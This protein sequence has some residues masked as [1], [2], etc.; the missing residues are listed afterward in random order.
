MQLLNGDCMELL[1]GIPEKSIDMVLCDLPYGFTDA[2]WDNKLNMQELKEE[3]LRVLKINGVIVLFSNQPFTTD[4]MNTLRPYY[5]HTWF[6][7]KNNKTGALSCKNQPLKCVEEV[8]VFR[9]SWNTN[10]KGLYPKT[11]AYLMEEREK[12]GIKGKALKA[13]LGNCMGSHYFTMGE[14]FQ[15]P[16]AEAYEKLQST[17]Y[18]KKPYAELVELFNSEKA[19]TQAGDALAIRYYPQGL[20][21]LDKP[22]INKGAGKKCNLYTPRMDESVQEYTNYPCNVLYYDTE[23]KRYHPTQKPIALLEYLINTYAHTGET[24]LDNTMG[25][26]S[27]GVACVNT[28]REFIGMEMDA[29]YFEVAE[30]RIKEAEKLKHENVGQIQKL[31]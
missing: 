23:A 10:N 5:S 24:V 22:I 28:G 29:R 14:Q 11:R 2:K 4:I 20:V 26:G 12:A 3:Y 9:N 25:S 31:F 15:L 30:N 8:H 13:L 17:G 27:T 19:E 21:K 7:I 6:W 18:F 16:P 1:K